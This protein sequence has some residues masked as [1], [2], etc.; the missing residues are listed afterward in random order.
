MLILMT[1]IDFP[2]QTVLLDYN[3]LNTL[4]VRY[5]LTVSTETERAYVWERNPEGRKALTDGP[6]KDTSAR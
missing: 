3:V 1:F 5:K 2:P 6:L 4:G